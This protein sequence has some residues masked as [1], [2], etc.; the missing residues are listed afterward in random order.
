M[1]THDGTLLQYGSPTEV[2]AGLDYRPYV[3]AQQVQSCVATTNASF[4]VSAPHSRLFTWPIF[5]EEYCSLLPVDVRMPQKVKCVS[6]GSQFAVMLCDNG[7]LFSWGENV[8]GELGLGDCGVRTQ[9][10]L[11]VSLKQDKVIM[12]SCGLK[13]VAVKTSLNKLY[14][15]GWGG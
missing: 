9:P 14:V 11:V 3:H 6:T 1:V 13:H 5:S 8:E 7:V 15:W 10:T 4:M 12:L 2:W